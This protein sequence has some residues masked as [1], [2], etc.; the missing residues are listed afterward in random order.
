[1]AKQ[2]RQQR[3]KQHVQDESVIDHLMGDLTKPRDATASTRGDGQRG[4]APRHYDKE[5]GEPLERGI[6]KEWTPESSR[7][8]N[9]MACGASISARLQTGKTGGAVLTRR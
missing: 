6:G 5:E 8:Q 2:Q 9:S 3:R 4:D 7:Q 1:M